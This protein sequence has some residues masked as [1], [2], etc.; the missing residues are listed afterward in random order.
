MP[1]RPVEA[2]ED[3]D[4]RPAQEARRNPPLYLPLKTLTA[5]NQSGNGRAL[6]NSIQD[7]LNLKFN[8]A[9]FECKKA[10]K[11][12]YDELR[13]KQRTPAGN[14]QFDII[15]TPQ[16]SELIYHHRTPQE[17]RVPFDTVS[18][19]G[20]LKVP[21]YKWLSREASGHLYLTLCHV[22]VLAARVYGAQDRLLDLGST[23]PG[24]SNTYTITC[25]TRLGHTEANNARVPFQILHELYVPKMSLVDDTVV[26]PLHPSI[27]IEL[28]SRSLPMLGTNR[29]SS[30]RYTKDIATTSA[31]KQNQKLQGYGVVYTFEWPWA[32]DPVATSAAIASPDPPTGLSLK[33][34]HQYAH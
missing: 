23:W 31:A 25:D 19:Q 34:P 27:P 28:L 18:F 1:G 30:F 3:Y 8:L 21:Y 7:D 17:R 12:A 24:D 5:R 22:V 6:K 32:E 20:E 15:V 33:R 2:P 14:V 26:Q 16:T 10:V 13:A 4:R 9:V 11:R 29:A